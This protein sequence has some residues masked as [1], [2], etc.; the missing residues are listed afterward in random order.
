MAEIITTKQL[1]R[2]EAEAKVALWH[3]KGAELRTLLLEM[4]DGGAH[5]A[6]GFDRWDDF[7]SECLDMK[8]S[9]YAYQMLMWARVERSVLPTGKTEEPK[10]L[11]KDVALEL[12]KLPTPEL[13]VKV[14]TELQAVQKSGSGMPQQHFTNFKNR[15]KQLLAK[16]TPPK[17]EPPV[18]AFTKENYPTPSQET[19]EVNPPKSPVTSYTEKFDDGDFP[20]EA[21][22]SAPVVQVQ[23][24]AK[25]TVEPD[26]E[27]WELELQTALSAVKFHSL[28]QIPNQYGTMA[29]LN[30]IVA[31]IEGGE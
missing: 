2:K 6:L 10:T 3:A 27:L 20:D 21:P 26:W 17:S 23:P 4:F 19:K 5:T 1:T 28:A 25:P 24:V 22:T 31:W 13:Q 15:V 29:T 12:A 7:L 16:P 14:Y 11:T 18:D 30:E 8:K 9:D